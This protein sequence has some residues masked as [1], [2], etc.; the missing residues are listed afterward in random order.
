MATVIADTLRTLEIE[1]RHGAVVRMVREC[2]V[3][4]LTNTN[5]DYRT[6]GA[7]LDA[8]GMPGPS[9][10]PTGY[11]NLVLQSRTAKLEPDNQTVARVELVYVE[12]SQDQYHWVWSGSTSLT[13]TTTQVNMLN[14]PLSVSH[15]WP[16]GDEDWPS[17]THTQGAEASVM[18]A[19]AEMSCTGVIS[20]DIPYRIAYEYTGSQ[21]M[22][23]WMGLR[24]GQWLCSG[25]SW[26]VHDASTSPRQWQYTFTFQAAKSWWPQIVFIDPRTGRP[27]ANLIVGTGIKWVDWYLDVDFN[28]RWP[29]P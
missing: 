7:A 19:C 5:A 9:S 10:F 15:T 16:A 6:V 21:N 18:D 1:E 12:R 24:A 4:G 27:P 8:E 11:T 20:V 22:T 29:T 2:L 14:Q 26:K 25:C 23:A 13:G 17:E 3:T 28:V